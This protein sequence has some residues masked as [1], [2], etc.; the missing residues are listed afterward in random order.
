[1]LL[2]YILSVFLFGTMPD[3]SR[4]VTMNLSPVQ[5]T[6][7]TYQHVKFEFTIGS[8]GIETN[9]SIRLE[10]PVAYLE[11]E[12][13]YW[14]RP[15]TNLPSG[16]G[17]V[18]V[19][20]SGQA[21]LQTKLYGA[22]GGIVECDVIQG[23][24][25]PSDKVYLDY[26]GIVQ[27]LTCKLATHVEWRKNSCDEWHTVINPS[28]I[29][30]LPQNAVTLVV[31]APTDVKQ[32]KGFD[33]AVV[34]LD[35]FGNKAS[36]YR[37]TISFTSTD[38]QAVLPGRY[39]FTQQD[40]GVHLF[41]KVKYKSLD[42]QQVIITD[43]NLVGKSNY[44]W[45][46]STPPDIKRYFGDT[47][48]HTGAGTGN[49]GFFA[50]SAGGDHRGNFTTEV[51]AY[52]YLRDVDRLDFASAS[53]HDAVE[54]NSKTWKKCE[55][56]TDSFYKLGEFTTFF[57]YEWTR[58]PEE[59]HVVIYRDS[60]N[61][62]FDSRNYNSLPALWNALDKQG[63]S[64][65]T[66]P[67]VMWSI[68]KDSIWKDVNNK[69]RRIGE[70]YSLWNN[71]FLLQPGDDPQRF[72]VGPNDQW[73]YQYAW[74]H[75][76]KIGVI[77]SSDNHTGHPGA[78]N[79][80]VNTPHAGGLAVVLAEGN[81]RRDIWDA[82]EHRRTYA[83]TGTRIYL[84]F[85]SDMHLMGDEYTTNKPP[86]FY[87]KVAGTNKIKSIELIKYD[88]NGYRTIHTDHPNS[89]TSIFNYTD[90]QFNENS[91]YYVRVTQVD[92]HRHGPWAYTTSEMAWSSPIWVDMS[93]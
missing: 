49:R 90:S 80:T 27:S 16:R 71:R 89:E 12:S 84:D 28:I 68:P 13:Y 91:F 66:I 35:K 88:L 23:S 7:G 58:S 62:V 20:C 31:V 57:A 60:G 1:M 14:D 44:S 61:K 39:A 76:N 51:E 2:L 52:Q 81:D 36:G 11:T 70:I 42:F 56:I 50:A 67:H 64:A 79:Y 82:F 19:A 9:G 5:V 37:G 78:N 15:Q 53:E 59:H 75:G 33:I 30:I 4:G 29:T 55:T 38:A 41:K 48:F 43:S 65:L 77:G 26:S 10:L 72:E 46:S 22:Y 85:S 32:D 63:T 18:N 69:Y 54:L 47:H 17:Y 25:K 34:L 83:T 93:K 86:T 45:V 3:S 87:V 8:S 92:E 73:S 24:L 40:S 21:K 74:A 6:A